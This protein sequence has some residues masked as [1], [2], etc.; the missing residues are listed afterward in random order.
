MVAAPPGLS[1]PDYGL[2]A[3]QQSRQRGKNWQLFLR[4][5]QL[6]RNNP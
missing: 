2:T 6:D 1:R 3:D 4:S 5:W